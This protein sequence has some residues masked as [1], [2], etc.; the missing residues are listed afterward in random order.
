MKATFF[1]SEFDKGLREEWTLPP[2]RAQENARLLPVI[3][4]GSA[5]NRGALLVFVI[6][7][8]DEFPQLVLRRDVGDRPQKREAASFAV[9][10]V[11]TRGKRD[12]VR[13]PR[14]SASSP[15]GPRARS[16]MPNPMSLSP[17]SGPSVKCS[18]ASA[19]LPGGLPLSFG[20]IL[21]VT[22]GSCSWL[23]ASGR[24]CI[25][26]HFKQN[27]GRG[28]AL[29]R[30]QAI[31]VGG[32]MRDGCGRGPVRGLPTERNDNSGCARPIVAVI[33]RESVRARAQ[34]RPNA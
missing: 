6:R 26:F 16:Q 33:G 8:E 21:M 15:F 19:S 28:A 24:V 3:Q 25:G 12:V 11:L 23:K 34:D 5:R 22:C 14:R 20:V 1:H 4:I 27:A 30:R 18:S 2:K 7:V 17:S 29:A 10:A 32:F 13:V 9:D 31:P